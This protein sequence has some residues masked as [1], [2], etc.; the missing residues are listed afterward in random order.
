[1]VH[2]SL[3][4]ER[5]GAISS[6]PPRETIIRKINQTEE[7]ELRLLG[8]VRTAEGWRPSITIWHPITAPVRSHP[9]TALVYIDEQ[10]HVSKFSAFG[11]FIELRLFSALE[12]S[13]RKLDI[14]KNGPFA[15]TLFRSLRAR[16]AIKHAFHSKPNAQSDGHPRRYQPR[17][18]THYRP[19]SSL[20][21]IILALIN[22]HV[23]NP[24]IPWDLCTRILVR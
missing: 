19:I 10:K 24:E 14:L 8:S 21:S 17:S 16:K 15:V 2:R 13:L 23:I 22:R 9:K 20:S 6:K 1:M 18:L 11:T 5:L 7:P 4:T 12:N 3:G